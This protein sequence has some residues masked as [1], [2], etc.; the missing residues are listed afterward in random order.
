MSTA[1]T[2]GR[3]DA[4]PEVVHHDADAAAARQVLAGDVDAFERIVERWQGPLVNL[5][6]RYCRNRGEAEELAQ[7]AFLKVFRGLGKWRQ[8]ARFSTWLYAVA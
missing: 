4:V 3:I 7:E 5:A 2:I 6:Y 1:T 8:E